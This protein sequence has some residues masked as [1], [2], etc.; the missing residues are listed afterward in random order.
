MAFVIERTQSRQRMLTRADNRVLK[1]TVT[2]DREVF[3]L[4]EGQGGVGIYCRSVFE[5]VVWR[6]F[7]PRHAPLAPF[8]GSLLSPVLL[9]VGKFVTVMTI[10][11]EAR[12]SEFFSVPRRNVP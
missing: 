4:L 7:V 5:G 2:D 8:T 6:T 10:L 1:G 12:H 11:E 3:V 9:D